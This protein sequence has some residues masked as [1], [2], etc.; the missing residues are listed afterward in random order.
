MNPRLA[1]AA[2]GSGDDAHKVLD[3]MLK[4]ARH[5]QLPKMTR[6]HDVADLNSKNGNFLQK[7]LD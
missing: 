3:A 7:L 5:N 2:G 4:P 6:S 1:A